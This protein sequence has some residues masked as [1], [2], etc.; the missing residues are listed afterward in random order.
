MG[1]P[2]RY[3]GGHMSARITWLTIA[4]ASA[5]SATV[6][7]DNPA[8][9]PAQAPAPLH[10][11]CDFIEISAT[12]GKAPSMDPSLGPIIEKKLKNPPHDRWTE[13]KNLSQ[14]TRKLEKKKAETVA[15]K[16]GT[17]TATLV[18]VVDKSKARLII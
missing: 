13:F 15:L 7:A 16:Q 18:E 11:M 6:L 1:D 2:R 8:K 3:C 12:K 4:M 10:V 17:A 9:I 5:L 14:T